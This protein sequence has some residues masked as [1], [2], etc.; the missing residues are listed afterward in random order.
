MD[1]VRSRG[2]F[3]GERDLNRGGEDNDACGHERV[4]GWWRSAATS[5]TPP[6]AGAGRRPA[7]RSQPDV[8]LERR[9]ALRRPRSG[10]PRKTAR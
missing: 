2:S 5:S 9:E 8:R 6:Q 1:R 3:R 7:R 4:V 10:R